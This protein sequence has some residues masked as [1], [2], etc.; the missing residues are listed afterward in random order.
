MSDLKPCPCGKIPEELCIT[1]NGQGLKW[2]DVGCPC[3]DWKAEFRNDWSNQDSKEC[4]EKAKEA[5]N[6][7][8]RGEQDKLARMREFFEHY[9]EL[10]P[11]LGPDY[12]QGRKDAYENVLDFIDSLEEE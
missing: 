6:E 1:D 11:G 2:L 8:R 7:L 10:D 12:M 9:M 4:Q 5:W 3:G